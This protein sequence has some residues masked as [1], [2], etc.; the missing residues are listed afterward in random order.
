MKKELQ[1]NELKIGSWIKE[2][3]IGIFQVYGIY[4]SEVVPRDVV[5]TDFTS[6]YNEFYIEDC[7]PIRIDS[8]WLSGF[9]NLMGPIDL[10]GCNL[11]KTGTEFVISELNGRVQINFKESPSSKYIPIIKGIRFVHELQNSFFALNN[12][13]LILKDDFKP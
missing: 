11:Y 2:D 13:E 3:S 6:G 9:K 1:K 5:L 8:K 7:S 10:L 4:R 12:K